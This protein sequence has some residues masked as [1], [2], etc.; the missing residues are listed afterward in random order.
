MSIKDLNVA[1]TIKSA[2][3][4]ALKE[5]GEANILIV[6]KTGVGK[7]T[8]VNTV[9]SGRMADTGQGKPVTQA[10]RK[11]SKA[12]IPVSIYDT[13]GLE[14]KDYKPIIEQTMQAIKELNG[15]T[16]ANLHIH[17]AWIC[18]AED[19]SRVEDAEIELAKAL[20]DR[21][22]PVIVVI[23]KAIADN[24]FKS[25]VEGFFPFA[26]NVVRVHAEPKTLDGGVVIPAHGVENLVDVTMEVIPDGQK[27]AFTAAQR[28]KIQLKVDR[29]RAVVLAAAGSAATVGAV[30]I[31]FSDAIGI[32]PVQIGMLASITAI[33]GIDVSTGF[34][35]TL[36]GGTFTSISGSMGGRA[37]VGGLLKLIPGAGSLVGGAISATVAGALTTAFGE[38]YIAVLKSLLSNNP[39]KVPSATEIAEALK[40]KMKSVSV[41]KWLGRD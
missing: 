33:F 40:E 35:T 24:G 37:L 38:A 34:L 17:V 25:V 1:Q 4:D 15:N 30:P 8:L 27:N 31:P 22:I 29:S 13:K 20:H 6:G 2:I 21:H 41:A 14:V 7:S 26:R 9:F 19:S 36:V 32:I 16:D 18:I 12:G 23:T 39:D 10:M 5:R 11:I 28:I 3:D